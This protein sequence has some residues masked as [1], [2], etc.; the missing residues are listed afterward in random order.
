MREL[1]LTICLMGSAL[2]PARAVAQTAQHITAVAHAQKSA[3]AVSDSTNG[4]PFVQ[5]DIFGWPKAL[6]QYCEYSQIDKGLGHPRK[7]L[8]YLLAVKPE[9]IARWIET[10][11][12]RLAVQAPDCFDRVLGL[13]KDNSGYMFAISGNIIEDMGLPDHFKNYFFR[14]G[15]TSA[16]QEGVNGSTTELPMDQQ[17]RIALLPNDAVIAIPSGMTR[18]WRTSPEE[19]HRRFPQSGAPTDVNNPTS[20]QT[21]LTVAQKEILDALGS[22]QNRLLEAN[23]CA[24]AQD[25]FHRTCRPPE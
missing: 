11:C 3:Y 18:F 4:C 1:I 21:W 9:T 25:L 17:Q 12:S 5:S 16:F 20:R 13:G 7:A 24:Q 8:A 2:L 10:A 23:L 19:F 22:G 6:I 15:M 14:N